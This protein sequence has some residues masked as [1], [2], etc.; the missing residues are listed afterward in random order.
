MDHRPYP[1]RGC[2]LTMLLIP[3]G[4]VILGLIFYV[5]VHL[6]CRKDFDRW[7]MNYPNAEIVEEDY[8]WLMPYSIGE[9]VR[10]LYSP[11]PAADVRR[12]YNAQSRALFD[13]GHSRAGNTGEVN[14]RIVDADDD[15]GSLIYIFCTCSPRMALW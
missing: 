11:D 1:W 13:E 10:V 6:T 3:V 4:V 5:S 7:V 14:W 12:W 8:S 15:Q 2:F 9:T